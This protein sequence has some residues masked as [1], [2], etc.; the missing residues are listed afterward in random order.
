MHVNG[1]MNKEDKNQLVYWERNAEAPQK[2]AVDRIVRYPGKGT[3]VW[4]VLQWYG[5]TPTG[6]TI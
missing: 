6:D 1:R 4:Y 3:N 5:Y 2:Y